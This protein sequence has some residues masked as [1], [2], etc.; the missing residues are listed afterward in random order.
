[1][2]DLQKRVVADLARENE[3]LK[4]EVSYYKDC[5]RVMYNRCIALCESTGMCEMCLQKTNCNKLRDGGIR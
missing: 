5:L 4:K 3:Q 1:M 2:T